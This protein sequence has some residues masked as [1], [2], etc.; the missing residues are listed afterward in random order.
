MRDE[1]MT[2]EQL[3]KLIDKTNLTAK[4]MRFI[5]EA[6][7]RGDVIKDKVAAEGWLMKVVEREEPIESALA[8]LLIGKEILGVEQ[9]ISEKDYEDMKIELEMSEK[10]E[11]L[12]M[13][14]K[15]RCK[16]N[17]KMLQ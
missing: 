12:E 15:I 4:E 10:N 8:M 17:E 16:H 1:S 14:T 5:G 11:E 6:Y 3:Q 13:L 7:L 2:R 9:V